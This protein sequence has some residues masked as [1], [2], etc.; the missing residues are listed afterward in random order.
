MDRQYVHNVCRHLVKDSPAVFLTSDSSDYA[1]GGVRDGVSARG[2]WSDDE[3]QLQ[4]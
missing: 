1:W 2:P 4:H 3:K